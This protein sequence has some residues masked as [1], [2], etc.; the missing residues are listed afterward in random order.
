MQEVYS[1][2]ISWIYQTDSSLRIPVVDFSK[3]R[4][5]ESWHQKRD[6]A[7]QIVGAF[8]DSGFVYLSGHG[9]P[10]STLQRVFEKVRRESVPEWPSLTKNTGIRV[11]ISLRFPWTSRHIIPSFYIL[12]S[13]LRF[14]P[15]SQSSPGKTPV[16]I[17]ATSKLAVNVLPNLQMLQ[18]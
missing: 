12:S 8:K 6:T 4:A 15:D 2:L 17:V 13:V 14:Q 9:I 16:P 3:F 18:R 10:D 1:L 7:D 5:A 11:L